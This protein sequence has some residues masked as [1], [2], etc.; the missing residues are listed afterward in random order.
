MSE[1][2]EMRRFRDTKYLITADGRVF[3][4]Y[5]GKF[6]SQRVN[7]QGYLYC[8][9]YHNRHRYSMKSHR[10]VAETFIPNPENKPCVNHKDG[11]K[12][13]NH[14]NNLEW[15]TV[16]ENTQHS[17]DNGLQEGIKGSANGSSKLTEDQAREIYAL[18]GTASQREI[19]QRYGVNRTQ[20]SLIHNHK[21]WKHIHEL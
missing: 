2:Q 11:N 3:S 5:S 19:A 18:K 7:K 20:V 12:L 21:T 4:E 10:L 13:N 17:Y 16:K 15:L 9:L 8:N 14:V 1:N 6:L